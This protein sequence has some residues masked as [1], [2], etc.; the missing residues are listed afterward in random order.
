MMHT[1]MLQKNCIGYK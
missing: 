1:V